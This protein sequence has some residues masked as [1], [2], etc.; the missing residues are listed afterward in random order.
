MGSGGKLRFYLRFSTYTFS[1]LN[2]L[3][4]EF[5]RDNSLVKRV[6]RNIQE[7]LTPLALACWIMDHGGRAGRGIKLST[8][9]FVED[10][11]I[12]LKNA[13]YLN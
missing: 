10:D 6:P 5:Y 1:S 11:V 9:A 13:L 12:L 3:Y 2:Y 4:E 8:Q 7:N